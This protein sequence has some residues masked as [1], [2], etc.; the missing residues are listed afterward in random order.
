MTFDAVYWLLADMGR[1]GCRLGRDTA[2]SA[3]SQAAM[4]EEGEERNNSDTWYGVGSGVYHRGR[5]SE[6]RQGRVE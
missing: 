2:V 4:E 3:C 1:K 5:D 6:E